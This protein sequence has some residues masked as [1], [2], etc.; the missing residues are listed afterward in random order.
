MSRNNNSISRTK[1]NLKKFL[2][3][4]SNIS[5]V[6]LVCLFLFGLFTATSYIIIEKVTAQ[7]EIRCEVWGIENDIYVEWSGE[8]RNC[9]FDKSLNRSGNPF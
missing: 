8:E 2:I 5:I 7:E 4:S 1:L 6:F 3:G 9:D